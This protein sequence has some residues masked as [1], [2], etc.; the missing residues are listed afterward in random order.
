MQKIIANVRLRQKEA[1][2]MESWEKISVENH[3]MSNE[4]KR[5]RRDLDDTLASLDDQKRQNKS[6]TDENQNMIKVRN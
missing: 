5:L 6:L 4:I 3:D 2:A 1:E